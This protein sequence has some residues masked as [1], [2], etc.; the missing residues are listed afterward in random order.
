MV[1]LYAPIHRLPLTLSRLR[2]TR[3]GNFITNDDTTA[4]INIVVVWMRYIA[5][6]WASLRH[7]YYFYLSIYFSFPFTGRKPA[8]CPAN[9]C[10]QMTVFL[11][12]IFCSRVIQT[13][14]LCENGKSVPQAIRG[15]FD[16]FS[17]SKEQW[18]NDKTIIE[19][20]Y[21]KTSWFVIVS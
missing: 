13:T 12:M 5:S 11:Q 20:G 6:A 15:W 18:S 3:A 17:W 8:I 14:L 19:L 10:L 21:R 7:N 9:N 1:E 16:S 2:A 4:P